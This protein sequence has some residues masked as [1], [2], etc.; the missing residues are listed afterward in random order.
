M[1]RGY[2]PFYMMMRSIQCR[3]EDKLGKAT[4]PGRNV[5]TSRHTCVSALRQFFVPRIKDLRRES[6]GRDSPYALVT[7]VGTYE[8]RVLLNG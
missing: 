2:E 7:T 4:V 8:L 1:T 5:Y 6:R 3:K